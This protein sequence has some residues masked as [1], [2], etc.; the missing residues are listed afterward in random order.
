MNIPFSKFSISFLMVCVILIS[1][2]EDLSD[3]LKQNCCLEGDC[4]YSFDEDQ[5]L[6]IT[7]DSLPHQ[8]AIEI[9]DGDMLVFKYHYQRIQEVRRPDGYY[10]EYLFFEIPAKKKRF[11]FSNEKLADTKLIIEN[12]CFCLSGASKPTIGTLTGKKIDDMTWEI[13]LDA[14]YQLFNDTKEICF[15]EQFVKN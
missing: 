9:I 5:M 3:E 2:G 13:S 8:D 10:D 1:C 14:S 11:R 12:S 15:Q 4:T 7:E 6:K